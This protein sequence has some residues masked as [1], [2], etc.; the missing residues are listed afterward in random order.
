M[1]VH[2][3]TPNGSKMI[4]VELP[5]QSSRAIHVV[6]KLRSRNFEVDEHHEKILFLLGF[7]ATLLLLSK[8]GTI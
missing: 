1:K 2:G 4:V 8:L 3:M 5:P 6:E 7:G